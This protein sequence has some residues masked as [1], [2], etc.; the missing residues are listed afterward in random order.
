[1]LGRAPAHVGERHDLVARGAERRHRDRRRPR[2]RRHGPAGRREPRWGGNRLR[3]QRR[4]GV[5]AVVPADR[6]GVGRAQRVVPRDAAAGARAGDLRLVDVVLGEERRTIGESTCAPA[7]SRCRPRCR[8]ARRLCGGGGGS[9]RR[10]GAAWRVGGGGG[11]GAGVGG[12]GGGGGGAASAAG[13]G[14][15]AAAGASLDAACGGAVADH[16]QLTPTSTVSPSGTRISVST[17]AAGDG[18]SESTLSV[19]TS[20]SGSSRSTVVADGLHPAW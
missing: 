19:E 4:A 8:L 18:T 15:S 13:A 20:K 7:P 2:R 3:R 17:P 10:L 12:G 6:R 11:V 1:M 14:A 9:G 16:G 5:A